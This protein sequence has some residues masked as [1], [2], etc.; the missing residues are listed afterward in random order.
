VGACHDLSII[1]KQLETG[2]SWHS[3]TEYF[4][5]FVPFDIVTLS[6]VAGLPGIIQLFLNGTVA[7]QTLG[8]SFLIGFLTSWAYHIHHE[9]KYQKIDAFFAKANCAI[10]ILA[11][12]WSYSAI[13]YAFIAFC[14][15]LLGMGREQSLLRH[16]YTLFHSL[17]HVMT[18]LAF[19]EIVSETV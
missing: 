4:E 10:L 1:H 17:F 18:G 6:N 8:L 5:T 3:N 11:F 13:V 14:F 16:R 9:Q 15:Y 2:I 12:Q 7:Y 19:Y